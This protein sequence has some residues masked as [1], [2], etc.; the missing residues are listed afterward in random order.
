M[1][2]VDNGGGGSVELRP[3]NFFDRAPPSDLLSTHPM[4]LEYER[5]LRATSMDIMEFFRLSV[6]SGF[7]NAQAIEYLALKNRG[8]K[9]DLKIEDADD[10]AVSSCAAV[11]TTQ[12]FSFRGARKLLGTMEWTKRKH[13]GSTVLVPAKDPEQPNE[14]K[15]R[16]GH[17]E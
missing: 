12:P 3:L 17:A 6:E 8:G 9:S 4:P 7:T 2:S 16:N 14:G 11:W 5:E 15:V 13:L 1:A 10:P